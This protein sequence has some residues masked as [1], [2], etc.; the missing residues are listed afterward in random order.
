[1][2]VRELMKLDVDP[3]EVDAVYQLWKQ[4]SIAEDNRDIDGLLATLTDEFVYRIVA[5]TS[6]GN[7]MRARPGSTRGCSLPSPTSTSS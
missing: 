6:C 4:H 1:M 3:A 7:A 2:D 5:P